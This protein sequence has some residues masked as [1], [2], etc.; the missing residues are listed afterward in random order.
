M[1]FLPWLLLLMIW[2]NSIAQVKVSGYFRS[3]GTYVQPHYR[4]S[5]DGNPYNNYSYPGNYNPYTGNVAPGN[6]STYL[7][8]YY[9]RSSTG[10]TG[11]SSDNSVPAA[12]STIS[13]PNESRIDEYLNSLST[14]NTH[15]YKTSATII[16]DMYVNANQLNIRTFPSTSSS[17]VTKMSS[18]DKVSIISFTSDP[19]YWV[20][21]EIFDA[22]AYTFRTV[23]GYAHSSYLSNSPKKNEAVQNVPANS[24]EDIPYDEFK[25]AYHVASETLNVRS[26]PSTEN[27]VLTTLAYWERVYVV[28]ADRYPW[29]KI[30]VPYRDFI[31]HEYKNGFGYIHSSYLLDFT[32]SSFNNNTSP[33]S[34]KVLQVRNHPYGEGKGKL[35]LWTECDD[36]GAI[37]VYLDG[38]YEG[39]ITAHSSDNPGC[40]AQGILHVNKSAGYYKVVAIGWYKRW[41]GYVEV[42]ADKCIVKKLARDTN[43][44]IK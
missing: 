26:G 17:I 7:D 21:V 22:N 4:S 37:Q 34:E 43:A 3:N 16:L 2:N 28:S 11:V 24:Q 1:K 12:S 15:R 10:S 8:N 19:W 29:L 36:Q 25:T 33:V 27:S 32:L 20:K 39:Q 14:L 31:T 6:P 35:S 5:P 42:T 44:G 41:E 38:L 9:N 40:D 13:M 30:K 18:G 23:Y